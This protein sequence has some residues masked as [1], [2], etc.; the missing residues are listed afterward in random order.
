MT[1]ALQTVLF[2][3][4]LTYRGVGLPQRAAMGGLV[5]AAVSVVLGMSIGDEDLPQALVSGLVGG[6]VF[7]VVWTLIVRWR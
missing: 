5:F 1:S 7:A 2:S 6:V 3:A 4:L